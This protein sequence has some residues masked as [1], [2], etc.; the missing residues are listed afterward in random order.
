MPLILPWSER[1]TSLLWRN[2]DKCS[3]QYSPKWSWRSRILEEFL[4]TSSIARSCMNFNPAQILNHRATCC[5][6][7]FFFF[8]G[9]DITMSVTI[10][11]KCFLDQL[12]H[13]TLNRANII[14]KTTGIMLN[15]NVIN[16]PWFGYL[17]SKTGQ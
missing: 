12:P 13:R 1:V 3:F 8:L 14:L 7:L 10:F 15:K 4:K 5:A 17:V 6:V 11:C 9:R 2:E 16:R